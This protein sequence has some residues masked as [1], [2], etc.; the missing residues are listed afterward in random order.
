[1]DYQH[2]IRGWL[3]SI[4]GTSFDDRQLKVYPEQYNGNISEVIW[5]SSRTNK[6]RGYSFKYDNAY[7]LLAA[8]FRAFGTNWTSDPEN[9]RFTEG[10]IAYDKMGNILQLKR[11]GTISATAFGVMDDLTYTYGGNK[12]L[13]VDEKATG[14]RAYGFKEPTPTTSNEF[15]YDV[16][17][18]LKTDVNKGITAVAYN[19]L[20]LPEQVTI[21]GNNIV[22]QYD[23]SGIKLKKTAGSNITNYFFN[24][25]KNR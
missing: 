16:N 22:Y 11:N 15:T 24:G 14:N 8:D 17:G 4:N 7:R 23:A 25:D 9:N 12:L 3:T 13:K 20:N 2:N 1:L 21:G 18:N 6:L 5:N 10:S 19:Y